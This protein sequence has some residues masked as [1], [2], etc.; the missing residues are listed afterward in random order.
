M[1]SEFNPELHIF[2]RLQV[3]ATTPVPL[4]PQGQTVQRVWVVRDPDAARAMGLV[5]GWTAFLE[6][7][8]HDW[9]PMNQGTAIRY[10]TRQAEVGEWLDVVLDYSPERT[11]TAAPPRFDPM[12]GE[13]ISG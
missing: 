12:T 4:G 6:D 10:S 11:Q 9:K 13:P 1:N 3:G 7:Q 8:G 2:H 5:H